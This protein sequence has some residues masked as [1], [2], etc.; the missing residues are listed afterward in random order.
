MGPNSRAWVRVRAIFGN[1]EPPREVWQ[2]QFDDLD[3]KLKQL[4][5]TPYKQIDFNDLWCYYHDL[6]YQQLQPDLF[7]YLFPVCLMDW[8]QSLLA[9]EA[10]SHG[11]S[12]F[13]L[14]ILRGRVFERMLSSRQLKEVRDFFRDTFLE[15]LDLIESFDTHQPQNPANS[16]ISRFNSLGLII[17]IQEVWE[18]WWSLL[19]PG[20]AIA[21]LQYCS[22][23]MYREGENPIFLAWTPE[24]GGGGPYLLDNDSLIHDS[25]W[26]AENV[27]FLSEKLTLDFITHKI[28][29]AVA[30]LVR[31]SE[32]AIPIKIQNDLPES[33]RLVNAR[34]AELPRL[35]SQSGRK[36]AW[37]WTE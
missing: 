26:L 20:R 17:P 35:L 1:P 11:D 18:Q 22:G 25:G 34:T 15:R 4:A 2:R 36:G 21:A 37:A 8:R 19:T 5:E 9:N 29:G 3:Y 30:R 12:E 13:H 10:C 14:G 24:R 32:A 6:A 28:E 23:L 31:H 7:A 33:F 16:W 27:S